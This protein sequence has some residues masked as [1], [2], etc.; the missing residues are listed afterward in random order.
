MQINPILWLY[1]LRLG[2]VAGGFSILFSPIMLLD[3]EYSPYAFPMIGLGVLFIALPYSSAFKRVMNAGYED[4][5][6]RNGAGDNGE[7]RQKKRQRQRQERK[8]PN[9][10]T[11]RR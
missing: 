7:N 4:S 8:N 3:P 9:G 10:L 2:Q 1:A 5:N 11:W 6:K